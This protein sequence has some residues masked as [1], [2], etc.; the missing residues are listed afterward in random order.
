MLIRC[1]RHTKEDLDAWAILERQDIILSR[2]SGL[3]EREREAVETIR[4]FLA[5]RSRSYAGV[6]WGKDSVVVAGLI[7]MHNIDVPLV[8]VKV[9]PIENPHCALVRDAFLG[10]FPGVRYTEIVERCESSGGHTGILERGFKRAAGMFG[11]CYVSGVRG[12]ESGKRKK[13]MMASGTDTKY[14]CAPIGWWKTEHVFAFLQKHDLPVHPAYAMTGGGRWDRNR[15]RVASIG[16]SRGSALG[17]TV[18]EKTY[19]R[20]ELEA[21][22]GPTAHIDGAL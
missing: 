20:R 6:S 3:V 19:Y 10:R 15:L 18:W 16:G 8:W 22:Y 5:T 13:R 4:D 14:T 1:D 2:L 11:P 9:E 12:A 21:A 7:A 17:R